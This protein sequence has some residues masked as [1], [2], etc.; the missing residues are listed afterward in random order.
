MRARFDDGSFESFEFDNLHACVDCVLFIANG[1]E[2]EHDD[3]DGDVPLAE[4][5]D[6][7]WDGW[8]LTIGWYD[9]DT[10]DDLYDLGFSW[11]SCDCCGSR[12]GGDRNKVTAYRWV[13]CNPPGGNVHSDAPVDPVDG[14]KWTPFRVN[15][16]DVVEVPNG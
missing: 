1:D 11:S 14:G 9:D 5:V 6:A 3:R 13:P 2:P 7:A 12:L 4:R 15:R 10:K 8:S 16:F